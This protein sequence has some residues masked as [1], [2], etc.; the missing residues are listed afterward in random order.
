MSKDTKQLLLTLPDIKR[1]FNVQFTLQ[2]CFKFSHEHRY[3]L[4]VYNLWNTGLISGLRGEMCF[5]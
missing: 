1:E 2:S 3:I 5:T 4:V